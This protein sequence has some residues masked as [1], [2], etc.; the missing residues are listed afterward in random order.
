MKKTL[1]LYRQEARS[2]GRSIEDMLYDPD[3]CENIPTTEQAVEGMHPVVKY[4][5][6]QDY[7][8]KHSLGYYETLSEMVKAFTPRSWRENSWEI[9]IHKVPEL[10]YW[11][12]DERLEL[13]KSFLS[14]FS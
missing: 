2:L 1:F 7:A 5:Y 12:E 10:A 8:C 6:R 3:F 9:R 11:S 4:L 14:I 13:E